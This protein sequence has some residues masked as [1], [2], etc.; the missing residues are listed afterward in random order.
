[1]RSRNSEGRFWCGVKLFVAYAS[2]Q[3]IAATS[4]LHWFII[5]DRCRFSHS[6]GA[7]SKCNCTTVAVSFVVLTFLFIGIG[8]PGWQRRHRR[9]R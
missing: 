4:N 6:R 8:V 3:P 2:R 9:G 1:M 7:S 5:L